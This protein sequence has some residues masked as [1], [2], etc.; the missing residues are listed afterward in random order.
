MDL[1]GNT[2]GLFT[3][4]ILTPA[5]LDV[6][7]QSVPFFLRNLVFSLLSLSFFF[8]SFSGADA[9]E[10]EEVDVTSVDPIAAFCSRWKTI[11]F[12]VWIQNV[13]LIFP[14]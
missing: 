2:W 3:A 10:D 6:E 4:L 13:S 14:V 1:R 11:L 5:H 8:P 9:A 12:K 7:A